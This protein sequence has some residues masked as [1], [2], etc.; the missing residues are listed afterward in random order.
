MLF[1]SK[2]KISIEHMNYK[3]I[4]CKQEPKESTADYI[5]DIEVVNFMGFK[6]QTDKILAER[7]GVTRSQIKTMEKTKQLSP[8]PKYISEIL[9]VAYY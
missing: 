8:L 9:R 6:L 4:E 7:L 2:A 1:R 3:I 5:Y